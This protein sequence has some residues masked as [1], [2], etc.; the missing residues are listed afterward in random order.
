MYFTPFNI[1]TMI[2][3]IKDVSNP[4]AAKNNNE[5]II[6]NNIGGEMTS[7][8]TKLRQCIVNFLSNAFK[9]TENGQVALL[10][11]SKKIDGK[12]FVNFDIKDT[13][14]GMT[15][16][17]LG[18][19]FDTYTQAERSTSA[20]YGGTG[21][22][23]SISKHFAE[24]MGGGVEVTS[25][26]GEGSTFSIFVPRVSQDEETVDDENFENPEIK[27]GQDYILLVDDDKTTHDV[28]RRAIKKEGHT[29]YSCFDGDEGIEQARKFLPKLILLDVLMPGRD[30]W[31]VLKELKKD[32]KLKDIP[33][34]ITSVL[35]EE[36]MANSLGAD[37]YMKKP[38]DRTFFI[39]IVK[40]Y[41]TEK[42]QKVLIVDDDENT[43]DLLNKIL[44]NE[45][46]MSIDAK[47]GED[48]LE[49]VKEKPDLIV[50]DLDMP[51]M[52]GFEFIEKT[53]EDGIKIPIVVF[54]GKDITAVEEKMLSKF[55]EGIVKKESKV[56]TLVQEV[57][58]IL[59]GEN[60][61]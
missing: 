17:Q 10:I 25:K 2:E 46:Y 44:K 42:N 41:I 28:V 52:D 3:T 38:I 26:V 57:N 22:G 9:F 30:G 12:E 8:E 23:L 59:K 6:K 5:F 32:K 4:L 55:T 43:R 7:D 35:N 45:G 50:L 48:A 33:V 51:R 60:P 49:R 15:E 18:K 21:L 24:M 47:N 37:D 11:D 31:S 53:Q 61:K 56:D 54:S 40:R 20:K 14:I 39:N 27:K 13:G 1:D 36:S 34:V 19:L 16:E 29:V 58:Q